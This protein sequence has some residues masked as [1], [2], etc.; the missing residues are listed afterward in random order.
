MTSTNESGPACL[1]DPAL[2]DGVVQSGSSEVSILAPGH[3]HKPE[4]LASPVVVEDLCSL[5][6][7]VVAEQHDKVVFPESYKHDQR[8]IVRGSSYL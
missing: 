5:H 7:T 1:N 8:A 6:V 4:A 2:Y 3:G